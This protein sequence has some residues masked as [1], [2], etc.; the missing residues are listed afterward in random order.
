QVKPEDALS[1]FKQA[2]EDGYDEVLYLGLTPKVSS[3]MNVVRLA[4]KTMKRAIKIHLY[5]TETTTGS[6]GAMTYNAMKLLQKGKSAEEI[7]EYLD[8]I[9]EK[10]YT[11]GVN[12]DIKTLFRTGRVKRGSAKGILVT[13]LRMKPIAHITLKDGYI[14]Y[15]AGTSYKS[16]LKKMIAAIES[17]TEPDKEYNL[18][19]ADALNK[20]FA[21]VYA[22][23]IKKVR[24]IKEVHYWNMSPV[25]ALTA[26]KR[27]VTATIA[28][29]VED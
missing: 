22:N 1:V 20:E 17:K 6:Q 25:M 10:I 8:G 9:K 5:P 2:V 23:E 11:I 27:A 24:K 28:P 14:G 3:Q 29:V 19:M 15:S 4:A 18:F 12:E 7:M 13:L 26:G 21:E 16:V